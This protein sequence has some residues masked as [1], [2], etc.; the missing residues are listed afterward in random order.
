MKYKPDWDEARDRLSALWR[1]DLVGRPCIAVHAPSG[2]NVELPPPATPEQR[3]LDP[4][5]VV[6]SALANLESTWWGGEAVPSYLVL[7]GWIISLGGTPEFRHDTIWHG[8]IEV[9][10]D[11]PPS[12]TIDLEDPWIKRFEAV[13]RALTVAAGEEDFVVGQPCQLPAADLFSMQM[14]TGQF[15]TALSDRPEWMAEAVAQ[16]AGGLAAAWQHFTS[17][18]RRSHRYWYGIAGWMPFWAPEPFMA[19][20]SDVSCM[21]SPEMYDR[22]VVPE[23]ELYAR[24][25]GPVWYHLDGGDARQQLPRLLSLPGLRVVQYTPA[26]FEP[27]NGPDHIDFYRQVQAAGKI[28]HVYLPQENVEPLIKALDP[29]LLMLYT[30]A[31]SVREGEELLA[32]AERWT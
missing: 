5:W 1:G 12:F 29:G 30:W 15:L 20:Q 14:G 7:A 19:T 4:D 27:P 13:L 25:I 9:D 22:F 11:A 32:A 26:S 21:L 23:L 8:H 10:F 17:I 3:W 28:L 2:R 24:E 18:T 31:G 6:R 16:V